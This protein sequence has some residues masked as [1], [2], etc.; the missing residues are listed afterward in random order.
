MTALTPNMVRTLH[1]IDRGTKA[2]VNAGRSP[3]MVGLER[4]DLIMHGGTVGW[5][6]TYAG[7]MRLRAI[8][9]EEITR[10]RKVA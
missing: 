1:E 8:E 10:A 5:R 4:R 7:R 9:A 6:L 2:T 3:V